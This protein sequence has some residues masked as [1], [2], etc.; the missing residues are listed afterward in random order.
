MHSMTS[1]RASVDADIDAKTI[2]RR[3]IACLKSEK[4]TKNNEKSHFFFDFL[5]F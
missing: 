1:E 3:N 4:R 2:A 5:I